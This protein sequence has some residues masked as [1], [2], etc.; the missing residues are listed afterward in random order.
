MSWRRLSARFVLI[1]VMMI[2]GL[3]LVTPGISADP[4]SPPSNE[5]STPAA[6]EAKPEIVNSIGMKLVLIRAGNFR[7]GSPDSDKDAQAAEK[8]Q[9]RVR[10]KNAFYLGKYEVTRGEFRKFVT[11]T[12]Y[13]TDAEKDGKGGWGYTGKKG[14][15]FERKPEFTWRNASFEQTD[16]H[17]VVNVS[18][19]DAVAFCQWLNKKEGKTY[20][21]PTEAEWEWSCRAGAIER[22]SSGDKEDELKGSANIPDASL[23]AKLADANWAKNWDDGAPFT[24]A[25]GK[26]KANKFG[27]HDMHGNVWEWCS[28][29]YDERYYANS[30]TNDPQGPETGSPRVCRGGSWHDGPVLCR[31][32]FRGWD[33]PW[34]RRFYLGFRLALSSKE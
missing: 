27:L 13:R 33:S 31:S 10:I 25:V 6:N 19:N 7:M 20:R 22:W 23:K 17:P 4:P 3:A 1:L 26:Y 24:S 28:D 5:T 16:A 18:W 8:P 29:S 30:P 15:E 34:V 21:L 32:A 14:A 9:H 12:K 2:V 11:A